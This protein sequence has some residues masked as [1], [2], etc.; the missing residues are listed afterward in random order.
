MRLHV[1]FNGTRSFSSWHARITF[2]L[3]IKLWIT[4]R[5]ANLTRTIIILKKLKVCIAHS[6]FSLRSNFSFLSFLLR[7]FFLIP[8]LFFFFLL[9]RPALHI[10]QAFLLFLMQLNLLKLLIVVL[11]FFF[12]IYLNLIIINIHVFI[13]MIIIVIIIIVRFRLDIAI[14]IKLIKLIFKFWRIILI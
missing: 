11:L 12:H 14:I 2:F 1:A 9:H 10:Y 6:L 7:M 5:I 4:L 13:I 3:S 8:L